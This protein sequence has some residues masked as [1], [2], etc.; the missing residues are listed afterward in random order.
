MMPKEY[1][2][3]FDN[4]NLNDFWDSSSEH[5][6]L[7]LEPF[8]EESLRDIEKEI[9]YKLP[10][11]YIALLRIQ[12][13]GCPKNK[14][15]GN[16]SWV[17]EGIYGIG[18]GDSEF[19]E[20]EGLGYPKI[21]VPI[22]TT[23]P[24]EC[25]TIFLDYRKCG[26]DGE[27]RVVGV[28]PELNLI[29]F[30]AKDFE[31]FINMLVPARYDE[32]NDFIDEDIEN[33]DPYE[34]VQFTPVEGKQKKELNR[35]IW[36][37]LPWAIGFAAFWLL[38]IFVLHFFK[39]NGIVALIRILAFFPAG[40]GILGTIGGLADCISKSKQTYESYVDTVDVIWEA[41]EPIHREKHDDGKKK[42][43][44]RLKNSKVDRYPN[45]YPITDGFKEGDRVRVCRAKNGEVI[46][47]KEQE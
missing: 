35:V 40:Y 44:L 10:E 16:T 39:D 12:N 18:K 17:I 15:V 19:W 11:S 36:E 43:F 47:V 38:V 37:N 34:G 31:S 8:S 7:K 25:S 4:I 9:G 29:D 5:D 33:I 26:N 27:P 3:M 28:D 20:N 45:K 1:Q 32:N 13:G 21:G 14:R 46:L 23:D 24:D 2:K 42:L 41:N 22:C 6:N 30:I